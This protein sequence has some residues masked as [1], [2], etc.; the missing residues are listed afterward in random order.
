M[1]K[2]EIIARKQPQESAGWIE[3][4]LSKSVMMRL[5]SYIDAAK[6]DPTN[7][8]HELSGNISK[9]ISSNCLILVI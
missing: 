2:V 8:N 5:E 7:W 1:A 6:K 9:L 3:S 4:K